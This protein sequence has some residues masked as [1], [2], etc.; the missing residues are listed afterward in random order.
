MPAETTLY[1]RIGG[2]PA[3]RAAAE[4]IYLKMIGDPDLKRFFTDV[5]DVAAQIASHGTY[6]AMVLGGP[7]EYTGRDMR[8]AHASLD[9][10]E[11]WHFDKVLEHLRE[12]LTDLKV[13]PEDIPAIVALADSARDEVLGRSPATAE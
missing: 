11:D 4:M 3:V 13:A 2:A 5:P 8:S 10:V 1:D 6:I 12:V 7:N 9:G